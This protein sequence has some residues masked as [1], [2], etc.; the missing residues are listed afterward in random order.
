MDAGGRMTLHDVANPWMQTAR[1]SERRCE[2]GG[3]DAVPGWLS[4]DE[5]GF[6]V[7]AAGSA[8]TAVMV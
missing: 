7:R 2:D 6:S 1:R 3:A 4:P 8:V 5:N